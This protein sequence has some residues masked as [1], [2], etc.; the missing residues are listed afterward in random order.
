[1]NV[2]QLLA[3]G[4]GLLLIYA[5]IKGKSPVEVIKAGIA[6]SKTVGDGKDTSSTGVS[7]V[8]IPMSPVPPAA[9]FNTSSTPIAQFNN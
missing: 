4:G 9:Q 3:L 2:P 1:M 6:Q 8:V 5:G 7:N